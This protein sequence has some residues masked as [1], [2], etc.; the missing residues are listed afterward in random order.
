M[1][2]A[3]INAACIITQNGSMQKIGFSFILFLIFLFYVIKGKAALELG[4]LVSGCE[5]AHMLCVG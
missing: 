1:N 4:V 3:I 2:N 5:F